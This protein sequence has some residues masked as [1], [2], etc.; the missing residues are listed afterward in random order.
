MQTYLI[1]FISCIPEHKALVASCQL[2]LP[3][4]SLSNIFILLVYV[5]NDVAIIT[6]QPLFITCEANL[7]AHLSHNLLKAYLIISDSRHF[8]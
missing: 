4:Y 2:L 1:P 7:F 6:V 5:L 3:M 8:T